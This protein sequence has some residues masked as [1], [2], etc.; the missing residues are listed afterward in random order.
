MASLRKRD[1]V[2]GLIVTTPLKICGVRLCSIGLRRTSPSSPLPIA[3]VATSIGWLA[4]NFDGYGFASAIADLIDMH[5][6]PRI[7]LIGCGA[8]GS[9]IATSL[10]SIAEI[11]LVL[12]DRDAAK[13]E[14]FAER[15]Q[16]FAPSVD[17]PSSRTTNGSGHRDQRFDRWHGR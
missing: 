5:S 17:R 3:F 4:A 16:A 10:V 7:L 6:R 8:A 11:D 12:F 13:A 15:L 1:D 9:A 2:L 14:S